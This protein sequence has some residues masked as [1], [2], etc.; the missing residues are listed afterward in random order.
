M[1]HPVL[2]QFSRRAMATEFVV[3]LP[4]MVGKN[5]EIAVSALAE[6]DA[7]ESNLS[8]Y[9]P[10]SD[11]SRLNQHAGMGPVKISA[12]TVEILARGIEL[13]RLTGGAFD[14][15]AGPLVEA[16][17][18][19]KRQGQKPPDSVIA[20]AAARVGYEKLKVDV[21]A[22]TAELLKNGMSV[23]LGAIGKGFAL[24]KI[25]ASLRSNGVS[26]FLIHSGKS[27][28]IASGDELPGDA[29]GWKVAIEHPLLADERLGGLR[30]KN[31]ALGTSG[32]GKQFFH[33]RGKRLGHVIDPRTG[34]PAGETL[35]LTVVMPSATDA[36]SLATGLFVMSWNS[37]VEAL[38]NAQILTTTKDASTCRMVAVL[39]TGRQTEVEV[40]QWG[41]E[42][43]SWLDASGVPV[44]ASDIRR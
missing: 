21:A 39:P 4:G 28:V 33:H 2:S 3:M 25:A 13:S 23:N 20:E 15:T 8:I 34:W 18:F 7:I 36:D 22:Q 10:N 40:V 16:W 17:G 9:R 5:A 31:E 44:E 6:V 12:D 43:G 35:S 27:S 19:T 14:V 37:A 32:S 30:L 29:M 38:Q 24:D 42:P 11:I 1:D 26:D 41:F